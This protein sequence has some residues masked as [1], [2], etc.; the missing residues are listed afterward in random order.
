[1]TPEERAAV[2]EFA[3]AKV[4]TG[5]EAEAFA[6]YIAGHLEGVN[7]ERRT[8]RRAPP[9]AEGLDPDV[10]AELQAKADTLF[11]GESLRRC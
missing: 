4:D 6:R 9:H 3:G 2:G 8:R 10:A 1:M 11:K 7:E 5:V